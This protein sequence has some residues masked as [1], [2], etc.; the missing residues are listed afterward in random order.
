L[1]FAGKPN[2]NWWFMIKNESSLRFFPDEGFLFRI[3]TYADKL[4]DPRWQKKRLEVFE[5]DNFTCTLCGDKLTTLH[6]HH[7]EYLGYADPWEYTLDI[8]TTHCSHCHTAVE[9]F[10]S[11]SFRPTFI[12][13]EINTAGIPHMVCFSK[14]DGEVKIRIVAYDPINECIVDLIQIREEKMEILY[15]EFIKFKEKNAER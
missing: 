11:G 7:R 12:F 8:L 10:K 4:K 15:S 9:H 13:K 6:V 14:A 5:R 1:Y 2:T 3:M